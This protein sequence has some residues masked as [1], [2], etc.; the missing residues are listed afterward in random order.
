[1]IKFA[2]SRPPVR[3]QGIQKGLELLDWANDPMLKGYGL[4]IDD[5]ML[6][7]NA[8]ILDPPE[9]LFAKGS[10]AKPGYSGRR[11]LRGI[12]FLLPNQAP[13]KSWGI[14]VLSAG[15]DRRGTV[16]LDQVEAFKKN[17]M[18]LYK[19]HGGRVENSNPPVVGGVADIAEALNKTFQAAGNQVQMRP[20]MLLVILPNRSAEAYNRVKRNCDCRFGVMSQCVQASNV[21]KNAPQYCSNVLMKFNCKLGGTTS[22][23]KSVSR[24]YH[25]DQKHGTDSFYRRRYISLSLP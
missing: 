23:L 13:L 12:V 3:R 11:D 15:G 6:K 7:T 17:F 8:R 18:A 2:V 20:Q 25:A 1:M 22:A 5:E 9:V 10:T 14:C 19:G 21:Q 16:S 4:K 24:T